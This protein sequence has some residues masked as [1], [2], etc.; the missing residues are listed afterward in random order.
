M[1]GVSWRTSTYTGG[2][3]NCVE[4]G[5]DAG[6]VLVRDTKNR[7]GLVLSVPPKALLAFTASLKA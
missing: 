5:S 6:S 2:E 3:G 4:T 7:S 1:N